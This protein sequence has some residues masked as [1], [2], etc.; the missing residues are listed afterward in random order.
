[1]NYKIAAAVCLAVFSVTLYIVVSHYHRRFHIEPIF[2]VG[3][4]PF[5][6]QLTAKGAFSEY[7]IDYG[8]GNSGFAGVADAICAD[9]GLCV[10]EHVYSTAGLYRVEIVPRPLLGTSTAFILAL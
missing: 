5:K 2:S 7:W 4:V 6:V 1:M 3:I 9:P 8:D 10:S